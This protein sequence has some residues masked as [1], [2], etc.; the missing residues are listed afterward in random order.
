MLRITVS[1]P[2]H[3]SIKR[4]RGLISLWGP[5]IDCV[6]EPGGWQPGLATALLVHSRV[7]IGLEKIILGTEVRAFLDE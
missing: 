2:A 7:L 4:P 3:S 1:P 6:L 5:D